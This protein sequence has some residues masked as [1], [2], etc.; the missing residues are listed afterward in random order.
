MRNSLKFKQKLRQMYTS[1]TLQRNALRRNKVAT[2][3]AAHTH[4][5]RKAHMYWYVI[6]KSTAAAFFH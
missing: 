6:I 5:H 3:A 1:V 2:Q 4:V